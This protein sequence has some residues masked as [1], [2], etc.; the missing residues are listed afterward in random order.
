MPD[1]DSDNQAVHPEPVQFAAS[2]PLAIRELLDADRTAAIVLGLDGEVLSANETALELL[3]AESVAAMTVGSASRRRASIDARPRAASSRQR[4]DRRHLAGRH[5]LHRPHRRTP[6]LPSNAGHTTRR[7]VRRWW[8]HRHG[9]TRRHDLAEHGSEPASPCH[10]RLAHGTR[11]PPP[12]PCDAR[13][14]LGGSTGP[15]GPRGRDLR[16]LRPAQARRRPHSAT[17]SATACSSRPRSACPTRSALR[18]AWHESAA[19]SSW[20][21]ARFCPVRPRHSVSPIAPALH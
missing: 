5:R 9:R 7:C 15:T 1:G 14:C 13:P 17:R 18:T 3:G 11:Q 19:T 4:H 21:S 12:D 20:W 10:A 6:D 2:L 8:I 16:R